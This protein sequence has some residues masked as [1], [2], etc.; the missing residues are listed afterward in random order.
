M[1]DA[2]LS[3]LT[4]L[5]SGAIAAVVTYF[6]TLSKARLDLTI[7]Y[8]KELRQKRLEAY[9]ELWKKL[10]PL[11]R[12]SPEQPPTYQIVK[13]TA[14]NLRD[15]YFDV[16]GIYLSRES[17]LPYFALKQALQDIIDH[18]ELQ[19]KPETALAGQ[20]LKPLHEQGR[21]L[22]ESLS[23]DIGSRRSPFV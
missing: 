15:W 22:R 20:W 18:P 6:A 3:L 16:G 11:A 8:D 4:G 23:N 10:K 13:A 5:I 7:E 9:R 2:L 1:N 21:I 17:R 19:K 14:E 12:Y